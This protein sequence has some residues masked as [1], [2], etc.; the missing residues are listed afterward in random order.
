MATFLGDDDSVPCVVVV[1]GSN[2]YSIWPQ[3]REIPAGWHA[4]GFGGPRGEC[5]E[6]IETIW[7]NPT[8]PHPDS[9]LNTVTSDRRTQK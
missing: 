1:N 7:P 3:G 5:L 2:Q 4:I 9:P 6:H 8:A